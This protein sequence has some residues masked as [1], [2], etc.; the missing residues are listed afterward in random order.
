MRAEVM[1][2]EA[3]ALVYRSEFGHLDKVSCLGHR[4]EPVYNGYSVLKISSNCSAQSTASSYLHLIS[5]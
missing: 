1:L 4:L 5:A 2:E 3:A